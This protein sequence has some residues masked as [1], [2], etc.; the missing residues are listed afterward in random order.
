VDVLLELWSPEH[1]ARAVPRDDLPAVYRELSGDQSPT[2][3]WNDGG[4]DQVL[5]VSVADDFSTVSMLNDRTWYYLETS[6][7]EDL[8]EIDLGGD[9][10]YVPKGVLAPREFGL[11]VLL[12][13]DDFP[14]LLTEYMWREQ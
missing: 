1:T 14:Y 10:A 4:D 6:P 11:D 13:A 5:I 12:R 7:E 9:D 3:T 2:L 8:V